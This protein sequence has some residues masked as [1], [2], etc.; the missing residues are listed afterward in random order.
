VVVDEIQRVPVLLNYVHLLIE[1]RGVRFALT[2]SSARKLK[3]G[4]ANL[5]AGRA[6]L[7]Y[8]HPLTHFELDEDFDLDFCLNWGALPEVFS[9]KD[10]LER[11]EYLRAYVTNYIKEEIKEEQ[12]VR[13]IE[14]FLHFLEIAAQCNGKILNHSKIGRDSGNNPKNVERYY[15][16]LKDTLLGFEI[17]P[18]HRS[19]RKRQSQKSKFYFF[20]L[21]VKRALERTLSSPV[22]ERTSAY[23]HAF[24]HFFILECLRLND[25]FR[26]DFRFSYLMT[27]EGVEIDLII[28]RPGMSTVLVE[29]KSTTHVDDTGLTGI[30]GLQREIPN[31][32][33]LVVSREKFSRKLSGV[34]EIVH[35]REGIK[36]IFG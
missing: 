3:R 12:I 15:E 35:W 33:L 30:K 34:G 26:K 4:G 28:E 2:G 19:I 7:N 27:K 6:L 1:E 9:L 8:L 21:G 24:E 31:S 25:Y 13:K 18:F 16:I 36:R 17:P 22:I 14:P 11:K 29:I 20:D 5:L 10:D 32:E 23:G